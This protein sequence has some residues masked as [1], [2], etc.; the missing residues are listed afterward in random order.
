MS[1]GALSSQ[2]PLEQKQADLVARFFNLAFNSAL[3]YGGGHQTTSEN[4]GPFHGAL[5]KTFEGKNSLT[6]SIERES[7]YIENCCVDKVVNARR[8]TAYFKK[9]GIQSISFE[10]GV[11]P[12]EI[13]ALMRAL[14]DLRETPSVPEVRNRL[15]AENVEKIRINYVVYRKVTADEAV[16]DKESVSAA[17]PAESPGPLLD[18]IALIADVLKGFPHGQTGR[19]VET[20][21]GQLQSLTGRVQSGKVL[22]ES[23][24]MPELLDAV[25]RLRVSLT[26]S[27]DLLKAT[28]S[29]PEPSDA[30]TEALDDL[31][32]ETVIR[33]IREEYDKGAISVKRLAQI[34][35]RIL[36]DV[37]ELKRMLPRIKHCLLSEGMTLPDFLELVNSIAHELNDEGLSRAFAEA[38]GEMGLSADEIMTD[39]KSD[40]AEAARLII[41]ASEIRKG[42]GG[43]QLESVLTEYVERISR[44]L[45]AD[46]L[47]RAG[48]S[49]PIDSQKTVRAFESQLLEKLKANGVQDS[50]LKQVR[51]RLS[52]KKRG[53][54]LPKGVF[55]IRVTAFFLEQEIKRYLRYNSPFSTVI[56]SIGSVKNNGGAASP[57][58]PGE[59][60]RIIPYTLTVVKKMLRDLDLVGVRLWIS[61]NVPFI[62]LPMTDE[63]GARAVNKRLDRELNKIEITAGGPLI[64]PCF[65]ITSS[66]FDRTL[67]PDCPSYIKKIMEL[68]TMEM[69]RKQGREGEKKNGGERI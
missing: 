38:A 26:Q 30:V 11:S 22:P 17:P 46:S 43:E 69:K 34:I 8:I 16:V 1:D 54:E 68:H 55:D 47:D 9:A 50:V 40:P 36:P 29:L 15:H 31:A 63:A 48:A 2:T 19:S 28:G 37:K 20:V 45:A 24:T 42:A 4:S 5:A 58:T 27:V 65:V 56:I 39:I 66:T 60:G 59:T 61:E 67:T 25:S 23:M 62:I 53:Y 41:L 7:V 64:T 6:L 33:L 49:E 21:V 14:G 57:P 13:L 3:L 18:N 51:E 44:N 32:N 35:R 52:Q 10:E 12:G